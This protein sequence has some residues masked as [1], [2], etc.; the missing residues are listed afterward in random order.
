MTPIAGL[1]DDQR[2]RLRDV[3]R[4][5]VVRIRVGTATTGTGF[6]VEPRQVLTCRHVVAAAIAPRTA[7]I[8]V[9]GFLS[10]SAEPT[11]V[12]ATIL[13]VPPGTAPDVA[14]LSL[15]EG[16]A[17]SCVILDACEIADGTALMSGGSRP[18]RR[19]PTRRRG[20]SRACWPREETTAG[21]FA[22]KVTWSV[23]GCP[24]A[25][26]SACD[27]GWSSGSWG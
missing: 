22:S 6:F 7:A 8:T 16:S 13:D 3:L 25:P 26:W 5:C 27:P 10:G 24:A 20:S 2:L 1:N 14:I 23:T 18:R 12:P 21:S 11:S 4:R 19:W 9:T 15:A 17:D